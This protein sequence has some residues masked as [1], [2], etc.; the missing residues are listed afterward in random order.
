MGFYIG[1]FL[2]CVFLFFCNGNTLQTGR[3]NVW[4][5]WLIIVIL[6]LISG[7]RYRLGGT[8]WDIYE[9]TYNAVPLLSNFFREYRS[10]EL[11]S[12]Y[13]FEKGYLFVNSLCKTIGLDYYG[14]T[15]VHAVIFYACMYMGLRR[16]VS[17]FN[18]FIFIFLYKLFF[19]N[20]FI[21]MRQSLTIAVFFASLHLIEEKKPIRYWLCT[22]P[23]ILLHNGALLLPFLYG[24][25][26]FKVTKRRL[27]VLSLC[28][29]PTI[30]IGSYS[31]SFLLP[32]FESHIHNPVF[33]QK[34]E[35]LLTG[36]HD[37]IGLFH[38]VEYFLLMTLVCRYYED[39][40][41]LCHGE[42]IIKL[43]VIL[44]P[45]FTLLHSFTILTREKDY[46]TFTYGVLLFYLAGIVRKKYQKQLIYLTAIVI[47]AFG[48]FRYIIL[49]DNGH[50]LNYAS[51]LI[52]GRD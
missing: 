52:V 51:W 29:L 4:P 11:L 24:L 27:E 32:F 43:F 33:L 40:A 37:G 22:V 36:G 20:T 14:F 25:N 23:L 7:T 28:F 2:L 48:F 47:C 50:L 49:F 1:L 41:R 19:Y 35:T 13:G 12:Y 45:I 34:T 26:W 46:F 3:K 18:F 39:L 44:L 42:F 21:S 10:G 38:V 8:D 17:N 5:E 30:F 15:L 31:L 9:E 16:Y 6:C